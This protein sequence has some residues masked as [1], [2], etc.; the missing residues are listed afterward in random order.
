MQLTGRSGS[1]SPAVKVCG[2]TDV[3]EA[4]ACAAAGAWGIG[5]VFAEASP[6]RVGAER[7]RDIASALPPGV[8]RVGVFVD[9]DPPAVAEVAREAGL[10]HIQVHGAADPD[11]IRSATGLPVIEGLRVDGVPALAR[12]R[13]STA[14][15]VLLDAAVAGLH[16]GTG[17]TFDWDLL[18]REPLGRPFGVAGGLRPDNVAEAIRRLHPALVDVSSGVER[19]PGRKD[20]ARVRAFF[21]AV[22]ASVGAPA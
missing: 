11:G 2:L 13:A 7:A 6:R 21:E 8:A 4:R 14:D 3:E 15:L 9:P 20:I 10:T 1:G 16:G 19:E 12:A 22:D 17:T 18:E 5:L